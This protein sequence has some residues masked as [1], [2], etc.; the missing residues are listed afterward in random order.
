[1][2][3]RPLQPHFSAMDKGPCQ[4]FLDLGAAITTIGYLVLI[5]IYKAI[6]YDALLKLLLLSLAYKGMRT[7]VITS[8]SSQRFLHSRYIHHP[9][10][11]LAHDFSKVC[12]H[13]H[14][15]NHWSVPGV[16]LQ[17]R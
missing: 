2:L 15:V 11:A 13:G 7:L 17:C 9:R 14:P 10:H 12:P 8:T 1:M 4:H 16:G 3:H 6:Y 5:K